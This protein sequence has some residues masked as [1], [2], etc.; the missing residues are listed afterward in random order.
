VSTGPD[1]LI[2]GAGPVGLTLAL[3]L[4]RRGVSVVV[5]EER[6]AEVPSNP[7]CNTTSARSMEHFRR[8]GCADE[9]RRSGLPP[10]HPTD[11]VYMT[12]LGGYELTRLKLPP[13]S[14]RRAASGSID[15]GW[16]TPEPQH[17]ISQLFLEPILSRHAARLP[18]VSLRYGHQVTGVTQTE[19]EASLITVD[20]RTGRSYEF[21]SQYLVGC[22]GSRSLV[23]REIGAKLE[24][25][26]ALYHI[27][28][29]YMRSSALA[30]AVPD[31]PGW[32][33]QISNPNGTY[34]LITLDGKEL[35]IFHIVRPDSCEPADVDIR[36]AMKAAFGFVPDAEVLGLEPWAAR[37]LVSS[38]YRDRRVFLAGDAAHIWLPMGGFGMNVGIG[39]ATHLAWLLSAEVSGW[40]G[41]DL[42]DAYEAERKP[43]GEQVSRAAK[44]I[45]LNSR[46]WIRQVRRPEILDPGAR[47]ERA[48]RDVAQEIRSYEL[49]QFNSVGVQLGYYYES[50]PIIWP[51]GTP[52]PHFQIDR[53]QQTARPGSRAPHIWCEDG[54]S[55]YDRLGP[56]FSLLRLSGAVNVDG[57]TAA[58]NEVGMP[59]TVLDV[60]D[61]TARDLYEADVVLIRPDQHVA[62]R[63]DELPDPWVLIDTVRGAK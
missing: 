33:Y 5:L 23:R 26:G 54:T 43:I 44:T 25:D 55:L 24:G 47:G 52:P 40:A 61:P 51:D 60:E 53:Y 31:P 38:R 28:S 19:D 59:L 27:L 63:G 39:D 10:D 2:V 12:E 21:G 18:T 6:V 48:R 15:D 32:M 42:L 17:R 57:I 35:W 14:L 3:D 9:I 41:P 30:S 29:V 8:L 13:A 49:T 22:D 16:P 50:S 37:R 34:G 45:G 11:V 46:D 56:G 1:V 58:A 7:K 62:W 20:R 4:G 36:Q